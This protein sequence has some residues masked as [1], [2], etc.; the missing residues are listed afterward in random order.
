MHACMYIKF[1][2]HT[3][4]YSEKELDQVIPFCLLYPNSSPLKNPST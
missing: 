1:Q 4:E 3:Y 2:L